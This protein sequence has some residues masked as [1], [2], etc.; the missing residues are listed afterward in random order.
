MTLR[1]VIE[2]LQWHADTG[3]VELD[4]EVIMRFGKCDDGV[5]VASISYDDGNVVLCDLEEF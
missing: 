1:R 4:N 3:I 2:V 5:P